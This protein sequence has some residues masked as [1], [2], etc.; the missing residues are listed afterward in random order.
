MISIQQSEKIIQALQAIPVQATLCHND[1]VAGNI[2]FTQHRDY[3]L[4]YEYAGDNDPLFDVMSFIT[5]N[6]ISVL[7]REIFYSAYFDHPLS[8]DERSYLKAYE[9]F[10]NLLWYTW[11]MMMF[12]SRQDQVYL[13]IAQDKLKQLNLK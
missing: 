4:D 5:E 6:K 2:G 12:E 11:A 7:D 13:M 9:D 8:T 3:L 1:W 10:H